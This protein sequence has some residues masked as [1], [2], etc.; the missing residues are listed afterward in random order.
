MPQKGPL[1]VVDVNIVPMD[2]ER[3]VPHQTVVI[4]NGRIVKIDDSSK[5]IPPKD[6]VQIAG[7][8][9]RTCIPTRGL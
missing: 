6:M 1:A 4:D 9:S 3:I 7:Q 2:N 5:I 8:G